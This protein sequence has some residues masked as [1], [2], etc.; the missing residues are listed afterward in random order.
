MRLI[1]SFILSSLIFSC[2]DFNSMPDV[3]DIKI[4]IS[5]QRFEKDFF[6]MDT[7]QIEKSIHLLN[8]RYPT[9]SSNFLNTILNIDPTWGKDTCEQYIK[10]YISS[11]RKIYDSVEKIFGDFSKTENQIKQSL[12]YLKFYFPTYKAPSKVITYIGPL[13]GYGDIITDD[14][15]V[16]GLQHHLG[17][18]SSFY[19]DTR[20][21]ETY[22]SYL[23]FQF[24]PEHIVINCMKNVLS[25][26]NPDVKSESALHI[27]MIEQ[28]K[29]LYILEKLIPDADPSEIIGY[30]ENQLKDCYKH[31]AE[32]WSL[33][34]QND[35]LQTIDKNLIKN[36]IGESPKTQELGENAPGNIGAFVGWQIVK[37]FMKK[38]SD[39]KLLDLMNM[40][41]E[42]LFE[43][44][45]YKP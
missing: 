9:F 28:G 22:P 34:I 25:D 11:Y 19:N 27:Q 8:S 20:L 6:S 33:F 7:V 4:N 15:F 32:I 29:R 24:T 1:I 16:I 21:L 44:A 40:D 37:K 43:A 31:E 36:Y 17:R 30:S 41:A 26:M 35:L 2:T 14:A 10:N 5:T 12:Q 42:S 38:K 18:N 13:D 45:K 3:S 39:T 23:I